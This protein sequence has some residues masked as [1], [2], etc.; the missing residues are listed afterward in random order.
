MRPFEYIKVKS[1]SEAVERLTRYGEKAH[2]LA[3]GT[4]VVGKLKE[5]ELA[6][7]I[8]VDV[9]GIPGLSGIEY[10]PGEGVKIGPL[11]T[12]REIETSALIR[13]HLPVLAYAAHLLGSVQIR[14]RATI[15]GNMCTPLPSAKTGPYF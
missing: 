10:H 11:T 9:K 6:P 4:D 14:H 5:R 13:E 3:G 8:L 1:L 7:E 12:I 2:L 15:R